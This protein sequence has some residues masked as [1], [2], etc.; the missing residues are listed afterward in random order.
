MG[1]GFLVFLFIL[2]IVFYFLPSVIAGIRSA[3]NGGWIF[4]VN[5]FLGWTVLG[6]FAAL[7]WA[8]VEKP[9]ELKPVVTVDDYI[10]IS[11]K[12]QQEKAQRQEEARQKE[13]QKW[14]LN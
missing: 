9:V 14:T 1:E 3:K 5:L 2:A 12:K 11:Q 10:P 4:L 13:Q 7:I 6:W 8:V